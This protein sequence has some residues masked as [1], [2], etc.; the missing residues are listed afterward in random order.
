[1]DDSQMQFIKCLYFIFLDEKIYPIFKQTDFEFCNERKWGDAEF[2]E[3][4]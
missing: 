3:M 2:C 4:I 1:M